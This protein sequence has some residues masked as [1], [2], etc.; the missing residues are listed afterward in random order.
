MNSRSLVLYF[1]PPLYFLPFVYFFRDTSSARTDHGAVHV[2][3]VQRIPA[4]IIPQLVV[5]IFSFIRTFL[6][7]LGSPKKKMMLNGEKKARHDIFSECVAFWGREIVGLEA[8]RP[9]GDA[10]GRSQDDGVRGNP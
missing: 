9:E 3:I 1:L 2:V 7:F 6:C 8:Q 4:S 10:D 5:S